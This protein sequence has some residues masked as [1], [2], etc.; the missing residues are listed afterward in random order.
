MFEIISDLVHRTSVFWNKIYFFQRNRKCNCRLSNEENTELNSERTIHKISHKKISVF[1]V[2]LVP[3]IW[4]H[5][6]QWNAQNN[7]RNHRLSLDFTCLFF[8]HAFV[9]LPWLS[10]EWWPKCMR[11][12][13]V[14]LQVQTR[15]CICLPALLFSVV[16]RSSIYVLFNFKWN[17]KL[18]CVFV[19]GTSLQLQQMLFIWRWCWSVICLFS[20]SLRIIFEFRNNTPNI[21]LIEFYLWPNNILSNSFHFIYWSKK[22]R[23][24]RMFSNN[25]KG[26]SAESAYRQKR[27]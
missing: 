14:L 5:K 6:K 10:L 7:E 27:T 16:K 4:D 9:Q 12:F 21:H 22:V 11:V 24:V 13:S 3:S 23:Q 20:T 1:H 19:F 17:I 15:N 2:L 26:S 8:F 25:S 18:K